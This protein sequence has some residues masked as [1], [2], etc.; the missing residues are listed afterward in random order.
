[1]TK[2]R[3]SD[4][5]SLRDDLALVTDDACQAG[6]MAKV[7]ELIWNIRVALLTTVDLEGRFHTRPVQTLQVERGEAVWFF[8][9]WGSQKVDELLHDRRVSLGYAAPDKHLYLAVSGVASLLRDPKKAREL[10]TAEQRAYYPNGPDDER[11]ALLRVQVEQAEYWIAPGRVSYLI[12]AAKAAVTG[13]PA[14][15]IGE[16]HKVS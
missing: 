7:V 5:A 13:R 6:E 1:M 9:G 4:V 10:W 16:N 8:T 2:M 11:L 3:P 14:E 12:A 15:V